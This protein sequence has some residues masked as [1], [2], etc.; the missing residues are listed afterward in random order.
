MPATEELDRIEHYIDD[1]EPRREDRGAHRDVVRTSADCAEDAARDAGD[2]SESAGPEEERLEH[3]SEAGIG[4]QSLEEEI[5]DGEVEHDGG[6][7]DD[8]EPRGA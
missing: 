8:D 5:D 3:R 7:A 2:E 1:H 4:V 6:E